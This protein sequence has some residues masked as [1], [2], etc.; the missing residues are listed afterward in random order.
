[1]SLPVLPMFVVKSVL[2]S[3]CGC[4]V[5]GSMIGTD[6]IV[7]RAIDLG[8]QAGWVKPGD[9]VS[10]QLFSFYFDGCHNSRSKKVVSRA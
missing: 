2:V 8:K 3:T 9:K 7:F 10:A 1:M 4:Q 5:I 6:S